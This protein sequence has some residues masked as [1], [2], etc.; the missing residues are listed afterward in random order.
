MKLNLYSSLAFILCLTLNGCKEGPKSNQH[1]IPIEVLK[2]K[3]AGGWAGKMI[4]VSYGVPTEFVAHG[5]TLEDTIKWTPSQTNLALLED[6]IYVQLTFMMTM[7][8]YGMDA[9]AKKFQELF[10]KSG[11]K[12]WHANVQARKNYFDSIFPPQSGSPAYNAHAG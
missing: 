6:D 7:D 11:Y 10:A 4:G 5:F 9:P 1:N 8:Q 2:D 12:L 3:I